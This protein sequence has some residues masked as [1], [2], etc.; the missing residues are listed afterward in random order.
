MGDKRKT[1][2]GRSQ[3]DVDMKWSRAYASCYHNIYLQKIGNISENLI[4]TYF[5]AAI[6][7]TYAPEYKTCKECVTVGR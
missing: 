1:Y 3:Q 5:I 4:K 2:E 7:V 6:A